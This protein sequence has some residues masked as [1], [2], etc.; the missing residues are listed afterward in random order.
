MENANTQKARVCQPVPTIVP[1]LA[2][3]CFFCLP[4]LGLRLIM[5]FFEIRHQN[6]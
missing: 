3:T 1:S 4:T 6:E 2:N 5:Y